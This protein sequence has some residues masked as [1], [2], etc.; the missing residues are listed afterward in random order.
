[1]DEW[2]RRLVGL[3]IVA[4]ALEFLLPLGELRRFSRM[5]LGMVL[6]LT[7]AGPL[8]SLRGLSPPSMLPSVS[9]RTI[10]ERGQLV[11]QA[12]DLRLGQ[13]LEVF[14]EGHGYTFHKVRSFWDDKGQLERIEV[15]ICES[16]GAGEVQSLV[17]KYLGLGTQQVSVVEEG[18]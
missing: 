6:V 11:E 15:V 17:A 13:E 18:T 1:M 16:Q 9:N 14:L 2:V 3:T 4:G 12:F 10:K 7:V 8:L 5:I